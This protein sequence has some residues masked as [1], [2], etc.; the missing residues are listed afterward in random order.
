MMLRVGGLAGLLLA[1]SACS[2]TAVPDINQTTY[3]LDKTTGIIANGSDKAT[4]SVVVADQSASPIADQPVE[5]EVT[6]AKGVIISLPAPTDKNG[7]TTV[8]LTSTVAGIKTIVVKI[9]DATGALHP[10]QQQGMVTFVAGPAAKL[11]FVKQPTSAIAATAI[12]PAIE[13]DLLDANDNNVHGEDSGTPISLYLIAGTAG[14]TLGGTTTVTSAVGE[15]MFTDLTVD[16]AGTGYRLAAVAGDLMPGAS[17]PFDITAGG[18]SKLRFGTLPASVNAGATLPPVLVRLT[19]DS[20]NTVSTATGDVTI[21]VS[22]GTLGGTTTVTAANG[23][24]TFSD[25]VLTRAGSVTFSATATGYG[26]VTSGSF[27]VAPAAPSTIAFETLPQA[28]SLTSCQAAQMPNC[29]G[30]ALAV[31]VVD[32]YGNKVPSAD[33]TA[34]TL[35]LSASGNSQTLTGNG[36]P[37]TTASGVA[38]FSGLLLDKGGAATF[39]ATATVNGVAAMVTTPAIA[40]K[41]LVIVDDNVINPLS[42][43]VKAGDTVHWYFVKS[44]HQVTSSAAGLF[45]GPVHAT[46]V[47]SLAGDT[48]DFTFPTATGSPFGYT[49]MGTGN[50]AFMPSITVQ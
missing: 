1:A 2:S 39:T 35:S 5:V 3:Q 22:G 12:A 33:P 48:Y 37:V 26:S 50:G 41:Q 16:L 13:V 11:A 18:P 44:G 23:V 34:V 19:D 36:S 25:L 21:S 31:D 42:V 40:F 15:A 43:T 29:S 46:C 7:R 9:S 14:A 17:D 20:G 6:P 49:D 45:C 10:I 30:F 28:N 27:A 32:Q 24:A 4:M 8:T 47:P 38:Q